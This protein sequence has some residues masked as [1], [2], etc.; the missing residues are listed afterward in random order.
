MRRRATCTWAL[1]WSCLWCLGAAEAAPERALRKIAVLEFEDAA[2]LDEQARAYV[3]DL[4]RVSAL[5][6]PRGRYFVITRESIKQALPPGYDLA[7]CE[8]DCEVETGR[9]IGADFVISGQIIRFDGVLKVSMKLFDTHSAALLGAEYASAER[10][11][12]LEP[13]VVEG[14]T[15]LLSALRPATEPAEFNR[16]WRRTTTARQW[17]AHRQKVDAHWKRT[18]AMAHLGGEEGL[19]ALDDFINAYSAHPLGNHRRDE[20][21]AL[22]DRIA[23]GQDSAARHAPLEFLKVGE[24]RFLPHPQLSDAFYLWYGEQA[25]PAVEIVQDANGWWRLGT[26]TD[27]WTMYAIHHRRRRALGD[28]PWERTLPVAVTVNRPM[29]MSWLGRYGQT[30]FEVSKTEIVVTLPDGGRL[31]IPTDTPQVLFTDTAGRSKV[32][33]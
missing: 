22:R 26:G 6:L 25:D 5:K 2:S 17:A 32:F 9:N 28:R 21:A 4:A 27:A 30:V 3:T 15:R 14:A 1:I 18:R 29:R 19:E 12:D 7:E 33:P 13:A 23:A 24:W 31:L 11:A 16:V 20:A 8:S 10:V